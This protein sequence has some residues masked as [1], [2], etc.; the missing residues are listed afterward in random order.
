MAKAVWLVGLV[1]LAG[2]AS[3]ADA[4]TAG[5]LIL[6][7]LAP[8]QQT[9][10]SSEISARIVALPFKEGMAFKAGQSLAQLDCL[11]GHAR[12][13]NAQ[14]AAKAAQKKLDIVRRLK[15]FDSSTIHEEELAE[16]EAAK[17]DAVVN[18]QAVIVSKCSLKAPFSGKVAELS[19]FRYQFVQA[20]EPLMKII[21]DSVLEVEFLAPSVWISWLKPGHAFELKVKETQSM[22]RAKVVRTGSMVD[23]VSQTFKVV[24][25][26]EE[27]T[28]DLVAGMTGQVILS[29][30]IAGSL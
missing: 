20:G 22:H 25:Q 30:S 7:Q 17:A 23:P 13:E 24:G 15:S 2:H 21:D 14:A 28:A 4:D 18:E 16:A 5:Q 27:R 12:L 11:V 6:G 3:A 8:R 9:V 19:V 1:L 10:L 29:R 26:V